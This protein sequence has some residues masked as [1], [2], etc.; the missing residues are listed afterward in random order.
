[1]ISRISLIAFLLPL[2]CIS[3]T[4]KGRIIDK[5]T[6]LPI[7]TVAVYFDNTTI[8]TTSKE[9]GEFSITY[10]DAVQSTLVISYLGYEKVFITIDFV[11]RLPKVVGSLIHAS[12]FCCLVVKYSSV[13]NRRLFRISIQDGNCLRNLL[14]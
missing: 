12:N 3:Q 5:V 8:G 11:F 6:Q 13:L 7:E 14:A 1:M 10:L 2:F 9:N 4:F